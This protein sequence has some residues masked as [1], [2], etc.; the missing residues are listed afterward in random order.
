[1]A[2][3]IDQV[4]RSS[5]FAP[6][7]Q[8]TTLC[9]GAGIR[10]DSCSKPKR[11]MS[12]R[13]M[14]IPLWRRPRN[15]IGQQQCHC[16]CAGRTQ[17]NRPEIAIVQFTSSSRWTPGTARNTIHKT[18]FCFAALCAPVVDFGG[19]SVFSSSTFNKTRVDLC[20]ATTIC[21]SFRVWHCSSLA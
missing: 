7:G 19:C 14:V 8:F 17:R 6:H 13:V 21:G 20:T 11:Q 18:I 10:Y 5:T 4:H 16:E 2:D 3:P 1:M 15:L 9:S 12:L